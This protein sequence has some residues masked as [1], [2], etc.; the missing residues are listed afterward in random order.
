M[1][2]RLLERYYML[3]NGTGPIYESLRRSM[4]EWHAASTSESSD[5]EGATGESWTG[6]PGAGQ[7]AP[8][9]G[10]GSPA[11]AGEAAPR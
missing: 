6:D 9:A 11:G 7:A 1:E 3:E 8:H 2:N 5:E 4:E 10:G